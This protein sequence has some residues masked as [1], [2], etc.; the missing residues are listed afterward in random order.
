VDNTNL[1]MGTRAK[2]IELA[3]AEGVPVRLKLK[4]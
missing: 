1:E 4:L 3:R 2:W